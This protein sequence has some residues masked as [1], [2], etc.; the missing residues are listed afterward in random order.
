MAIRSSQRLRSRISNGVDRFIS[1]CLLLNCMFVAKAWITK[2]TFA[3]YIQFFVQVLKPTADRPALL[4]VDNHV[5]RFNADMM[6]FARVNHVIMFSLPPNSTDKVQPLDVSCHR[7][8]KAYLSAEIERLPADFVLKPWNIV[9]IASPAWSKAMSPANIRSGFESTGIAP[10]DRTAI[11]DS[12][13]APA[14]AFVADA[15]REASVNVSN[16]IPVPADLQQ[17]LHIPSMPLPPELRKKG[18]SKDGSAGYSLTQQRS[19]SFA[20]PNRSVHQKKQPKLKKVVVVAAEAVDAVAVA[21]AVAVE[22][23]VEVV[24]TVNEKNQT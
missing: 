18:E 6:E 13:L 21:V 17:V 19:S 4:L 1:L 23:E 7:P 22:V 2:A 14:E 20:K 16:I 9:E 11:P 8:F 10:F 24:E 12:E 3:A 15:A 5:S